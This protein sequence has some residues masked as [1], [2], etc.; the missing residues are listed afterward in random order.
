[1][2][3]KV[4]VDVSSSRVD[5][6]FDYLVPNYL[7]Q[8]IKIGSRV[9]V[10]FGVRQIFGFVLG[11][12]E[13]TSYEGTTKEIIELLDLEPLISSEQ[14][15]LATHLRNT[16][17]SMM[18]SCLNLMIPD[19]LKG[20]TDKFLNIIDESGLDAELTMA[21]GGGKRVKFTPEMH[22]LSNKLKK[23]I[24]LGQI[25]QS[26][27]A[28][29]K[30]NIKYIKKYYLKEQYK[31]D[32]FIEIK[33]I[34]KKETLYAMQEL[35]TSMSELELCEYAGCSAYLI[36]SLVDLGYLGVEKLEIHR[37]QLETLHHTK[38]H[39]VNE[40]HPLLKEIRENNKKPILC[41][42]SNSTQTIESYLDVIGQHIKNKKKVLF[43]VPNLIL[44]AQFETIFQTKLNCEIAIFDS[45]ISKGEYYDSYRRFCKGEVD[46]AIG[47]KMAAFLPIEQVDLVIVDG[48]ESL[49]YINNQSPKYHMIEALKY[50]LKQ[51]SFQLLLSSIS[52]S[53]IS[54]DKAIRGEYRLFEQPP[55]KY[56][57]VAVVD[58]KQELSE[59][60]R[61]VFSR[62]LH[63]EIELR[64]I[65]K[66]QTMLILNNK[67][68]SQFVICRECGLVMKCPKC[69]VSLSYSK[70]QD[71]LYCGYCSYKEPIPKTCPKC[72][73]SY[74]RHMG[75]GLEK[76]E[77]S[78]H[79]EFPEA[80]ILRIDADLN[81]SSESYGQSIA[82]IE[83]Q[84]V[85]IIIG[86]EVLVRL[87][88]FDQITLIG[89]L[90]ADLLLNLPDY[91][92]RER[93]FQMIVHTSSKLEEVPNSLTIIQVY[94]SSS[95]TI[96][97]AV[98]KD[99]LGFLKEEYKL[100]QEG[101][102]PPFMTVNRI[103]I[104]GPYKETFK[105]GNTIKK[106]LQNVIKG[107]RVILGPNINE[108]LKSIQLIIKY[109]SNF[110]IDNAYR[111]IYDEYQDSKYE[112]HF[113]RYP[114]TL[115]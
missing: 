82:M 26:Y 13:S 55:E 102:Y 8:L 25:E 70:Q 52:P 101:E 53:L 74:I 35:S 80:R 43:I 68:Y 40:Q 69:K 37:N 110:S 1:M 107:N 77:E 79:Q 99:Y 41:H 114:Q 51:Q 20:K 15:M 16:T 104:K 2:Y 47:T 31:Y 59:G 112:V 71:Q 6:E 30:G 11:L 58:M 100:R 98:T 94:E 38:K 93:T 111:K 3:A 65:R 108:K 57:Q 67:G 84:E 83:D 5:M 88:T 73:S 91:Q 64:L 14:L 17:S 113:E 9:I 28:K 89:I 95:P 22:R 109:D 76:L 103:L 49:L 54:Y 32:D 21:F 42:F 81:Q 56:P 62:T 45:S 92:A 23:A 10:P 60:N 96:K 78:L 75:L 19:S 7:E 85:D 33:S 12:S 97:S 27:V 72:G 46:L 106:S 34:R 44:I 87:I 48:E 66:E 24:D 36:H 86:T 115:V 29:Q 90:S 18:I 63:S 105:I 4:I 61:S 50:R 39:V